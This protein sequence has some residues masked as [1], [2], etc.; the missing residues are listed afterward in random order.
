MRKSAD[1]VTEMSEWDTAVNCESVEFK[2]QL[3][4][5]EAQRKLTDV[6]SPLSMEDISSV[7]NIPNLN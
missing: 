7:S 1:M 3:N 4:V 5:F 6:K 2:D